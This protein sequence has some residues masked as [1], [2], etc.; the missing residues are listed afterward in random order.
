MTSI[1]SSS[2]VSSTSSLLHCISDLETTLEYPEGGPRRR[3]GAEV[4]APMAPT[5]P[6][7]RIDV[8]EP[9]E[10]EETAPVTGSKP[11]TTDLIDLRD[12]SNHIGGG[13]GHPPPL[14]LTPQPGLVEAQNIHVSAPVIPT[15]Q[16]QQ[17]SPT[18]PPRKPD[19]HKT[20]AAEP[21]SSVKSEELIMKD[22]ILTDSSIQAS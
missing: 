15:H 9:E 1:R 11:D 14:P 5:H 19:P 22:F 21:P 10:S 18:V 2:G 12:H 16:P 13:G 4:T 3:S 20:T 6:G 17:C 8:I 7:V